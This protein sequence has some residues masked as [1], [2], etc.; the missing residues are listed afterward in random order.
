MH[1]SP[2]RPAD[3]LWT[4][5]LVSLWVLGWPLMF[6]GLFSLPCSLQGD[7]QMHIC[8]GAVGLR[9][10][11]MEERPVGWPRGGAVEGSGSRGL[12]PLELEAGA[13]AGAV[14]E[15][16]G[17]VAEGPGRVVWPPSRQGSS[18]LLL[19]WGS[20]TALFRGLCPGVCG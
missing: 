16:E 15:G 4:L 18:V 17:G 11:L 14:A 20:S 13:W 2:S 6:P 5:F 8:S 19:L 10:D 1:A 12:G 3:H 7:T 9:W